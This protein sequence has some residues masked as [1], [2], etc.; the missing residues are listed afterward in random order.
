MLVIDSR[1][2]QAEDGFNENGREFSSARYDID[3][4]C[5]PSE[6]S[7]YHHFSSDDALFT[8]FT[9]DIE[10]IDLIQL[11]KDHENISTASAQCQDVEFSDS[12]KSTHRWHLE[13]LEDFHNDRV[14]AGCMHLLPR[15]SLSQD[16]CMN[17]ASHPKLFKSGTQ[18]AWSIRSYKFQLGLINTREVSGRNFMHDSPIGHTVR[19]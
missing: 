10:D 19:G 12:P 3:G 8:T 9:D 5:L 6:S 4:K 16:D 15:R 17:S 1:P 13:D 2:C 11:N 7:Q 14:Y 18:Q